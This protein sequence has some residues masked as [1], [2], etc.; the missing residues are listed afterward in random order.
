MLFFFEA[1][2]VE[3]LCDSCVFAVLRPNDGRL[4]IA[5]TTVPIQ[6]CVV[7]ESADS[8]VTYILRNLSNESLK[9]NK[10]TTSKFISHVHLAEYCH[11]KQTVR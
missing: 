3:R 8:K 1:A 7:N 6:I 9:K 2:A 11:K 10:K 4:S 5:Q